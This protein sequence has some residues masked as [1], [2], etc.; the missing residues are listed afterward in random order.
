[1]MLSVIMPVYKVEKYIAQCLEGVICQTFKDLEI[2]VIDDGSPD[3]SAQIYK[4]YAKLDSRIRIVKQKNSGVSAAR[5]RG[6]EMARGKYVHFIDSDDYLAD[7]NFYQKM[8]DAALSNNCDMAVSGFYFQERPYQS[9]EYDCCGIYVGIDNKVRITRFF[10]HGYIWRYIYDRDFLIRNK[11]KF[12]IG[13][14]IFEDCKFGLEALEKSNRIIT[15]PDVIYFYRHRPDSRIGISKNSK[16]DKIKYNLLMDFYKDFAQRHQCEDAG[17][18]SNRRFVYKSF[19]N[20]NLMTIKQ[21]ND[22]SK[23]YLFG[24]IRFLKKSLS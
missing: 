2:L 10:E 3:K 20:I 18:K 14:T 23:Y 15:V 16:Q 1:M 24:L 6:L 12:P 8:I 9:V 19:F 7:L 21:E 13:Q 17:V 22:I 5:N 11:L 4:R